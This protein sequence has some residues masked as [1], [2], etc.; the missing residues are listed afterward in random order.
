[1]STEVLHITIPTELANRI[2]DRVRSGEYASE[3]DVIIHQFS[4][5]DDPAD[6]LSPEEL[7]EAVA[8]LDEMER[9]R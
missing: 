9:H 6:S 4:H 2:R 3:S 1:M 7:E 5:E 8:I